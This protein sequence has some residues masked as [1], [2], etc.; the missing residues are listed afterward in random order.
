MSYMIIYFNALYIFKKNQIMGNFSL[1]LVDSQ[2]G[3]GE[4]YPMGTW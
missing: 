4:Q 1:Y 2:L 3:G